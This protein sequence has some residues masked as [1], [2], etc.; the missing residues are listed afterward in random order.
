MYIQA[1]HLNMNLDEFNEFY[2]N[3]LLDKLSKENKVSFETSKINLL[4][5][6][7][8]YEQMNFLI[9]YFHNC[10]W[11]IYLNL[12][13]WLVKV[14]KW[15]SDKTLIQ[16]MLSNELSISILSYNATSSILDH[17]PQFLIVSNI[18]FQF[19]NLKIYD[20]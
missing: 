1:S 20:I 5:M 3:D 9:L 11:P 17:L 15:Q 8:A 13:E 16:N 19:P 14:T 4:I 10:F 7:T 6:I 18:F 2:R 12:K